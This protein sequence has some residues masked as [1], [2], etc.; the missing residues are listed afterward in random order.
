MDKYNNLQS[1]YKNEPVF[2]GVEGFLA[3][4]SNNVNQ[5]SNNFNCSLVNTNYNNTSND[6][7]NDNF[8]DNFNDTSND[9]YNN[10]ANNTFNDTFNNTYND[11]ELKHQYS[12]SPYIYSSKGYLYCV[13]KGLIKDF[14]EVLK[15]CQAS[16]YDVLNVLNKPFKN[17]IYHIDDQFLKQAFKP[18]DINFEVYD[19]NNVYKNIH[20][21]LI[22]KQYPNYNLYSLIIGIL[23]RKYFDMNY[24]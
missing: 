20:L 15:N 14:S 17:N 13:N 10:T 2:Y 6:T 3:H 24:F 16:S 19:S 22:Q 9:T 8:N 1:Y 4:F 11:T 23:K 7:Y 12:W 5:S 21:K 18:N